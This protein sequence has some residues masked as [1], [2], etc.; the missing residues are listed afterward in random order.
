MN[1]ALRSIARLAD[2]L[3][4]DQYG[5]DTGNFAIVAHTADGQPITRNQFNQ[6]KRYG[7]TILNDGRVF[8][9][10]DVT[11]IKHG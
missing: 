7:G 6:L 4:T 3:T 11:A 8:D 2:T 1:F 9:S 10:T 5:L